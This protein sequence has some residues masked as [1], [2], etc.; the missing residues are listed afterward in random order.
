MAAGKK[1]EFNE[2]FISAWEIEDCLWNV[3]SDVFKDRNLRQTAMKRI[4][5][6][7]EMSGDFLIILYKG[8]IIIFLEET[9]YFIYFLV[10]S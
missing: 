3:K 5:E 9:F 6:L 4:A 2:N 10:T 8:S 7:F 1:I